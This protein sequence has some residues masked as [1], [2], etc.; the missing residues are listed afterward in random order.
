MGCTRQAMPQSMPLT[1]G[2]T[3]AVFGALRSLAIAL[4]DTYTLKMQ[5]LIRRNEEVVYFMLLEKSMELILSG[6]RRNHL[7]SSPMEHKKRSSR[8]LISLLACW[9]VTSYSA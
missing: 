2:N 3:L 5:W 4:P 7:A 1:S 8:M 6:L 9:L